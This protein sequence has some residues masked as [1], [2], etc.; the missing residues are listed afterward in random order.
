MAGGQAAARKAETIR[1]LE[2][3]AVSLFARKW[4]NTVSVAEICREAGLSNGIFYRY[5]AGKEELFRKLLEGIVESIR[6]ALGGI[7]GRDTAERLPVFVRGV[8][9]YSR[10]RPELVSVFREGQY[11]FFE[12]ERKLEKLYR[13]VLTTVLGRDIGLAEYLYAY[14]GIRFCAVRAGLQGVKI[15]E[16]V[17]IDIVSRGIFRGL[18]F[19]SEKVFGGAAR[20]P[21]IELDSTAR[22]RLVSAGKR[23][24][25]EKG[26]FETNIHEI[27]DSAGLSVG[28][29]Y[30]HFEGKEQFYA[31]LIRRAGSDIRSFIAANMGEGLN[32][33]EREL[34]GIWLFIVFL[35]IDRNCYEIVREAE[36]V[37]PGEV[38]AYYG[39]FVEGYR[40]NPD[41]NGE[42]AAAGTLAET[43]VIEYLIGIAH[44]FGIEVAFDGS[45][46]V[47][48]ATLEAMGKYLASGFSSYL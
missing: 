34:R 45:G 39:A 33:L 30:S 32:R 27:T 13:D 21:A 1:K 40:H 9:G 31:E 7:E 15:D 5:Y 42:P 35:S 2:A 28:A 18:S 36:F 11:R 41:G 43:T 23:L 26:Y 4:Y 47:A 29:F 38:K 25:G 20:P 24:F 6:E 46:A 12:Y 10:E 8:I 17:V 16:K 3:A 22:D 37:L 44:Y 48:R 14:G 19:E